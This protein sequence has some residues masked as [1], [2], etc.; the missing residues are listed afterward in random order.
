MKTILSFFFSCFWFVLS[1][2]TPV[3]QVGELPQ[4]VWE[5]SGLLFYNSKLITHNDSGNSA[6]LYEI[7]TVSM[8]VSRSV[9][10][11]NALNIDWE[12]IAQDEDYIYIADFGNNLGTRQDLSV[13]RIAKNSYNSVDAVSAEELGFA[14]EDQTD[15]SDTGNSDW[16]AEA[17]F[18]LEDRLIILTKQWQSNS[19]VAYSIPKIPGNHTA[20]RL[21]TYA[22]NGLVTAATYNKATKILYVLGYNSLLGS[23][24][25]RITGATTTAIFAGEVEELATDIGFSQTEGITFIGDNDYLISSERFVNEQRGIEL[26]SLLVGFKTNDVETGENLN[27]EGNTDFFLYRQNGSTDLRYQLVTDQPVLGWAIFDSTGRRVRYISEDIL[28]NEVIDVA[29]LHPAIY[30]FS[31]YLGNETLSRA[32]AVD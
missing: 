31:L 6:Q 22:I 16:D 14:Y 30:Y 26:P 17:L 12:D 5:T 32:F 29:T 4:R 11:S 1:S 2:Q 23:F 25:Y 15:F 24:V 27:L 3:R 13:Y 7:D 19:T 18:V 20:R 8:S 28:E 10:I 21:D 9:T